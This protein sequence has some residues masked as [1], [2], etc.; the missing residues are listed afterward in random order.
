[1]ENKARRVFASFKDEADGDGLL[2]PK[3]KLTLIWIAP[4]S[5]AETQDGGKYHVFIVLEMV[6][7]PDN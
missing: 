6:F 2:I 3:L 1:M 7:F 4:T 5:S